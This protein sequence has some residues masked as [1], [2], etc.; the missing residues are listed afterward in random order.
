MSATVSTIGWVRRDKDLLLIYLIWHVMCGNVSWLN[1][2][3]VFQRLFYYTKIRLFLHSLYPRPNSR[4][5][6]QWLPGK[7]L[8]DT[9][10]LMCSCHGRWQPAGIHC[11]P[12]VFI[13]GSP[14]YIDV[15][16]DRPRYS[17]VN[18]QAVVRFRLFG[19]RVISYVLA[20]YISYVLWYNHFFWAEY[21]WRT[22]CISKF[23]T[24]CG[25]W[26]GS[27]N[28]AYWKSWNCLSCI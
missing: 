5:E 21:L 13:A 22:C 24:I 18:K 6:L 10:A 20:W 11:R 25:R 12:L 19:E 16:S 1:T 3:L 7:E 28:P 9:Q 4:E 2:T 27:R 8:P 17:I 15:E 14:S 23:C 26:T